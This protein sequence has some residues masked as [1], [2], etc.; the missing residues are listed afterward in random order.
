MMNGYILNLYHAIAL[1]R[2]S[3]PKLTNEN[4]KQECLLLIAKLREEILKLCINDAQKDN[5]RNYVSELMGETNPYSI[6]E[7]VGDKQ[8]MISLESYLNMPPDRYYSP[9]EDGDAIIYT[10]L[11]HDIETAPDV[12]IIINGKLP[13]ADVSRV[14]KK[15]VDCYNRDDAMQKLV[16]F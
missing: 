3:L 10:I 9:D 5:L 11:Q 1:N 4:D 15:M 16:E 2:I 14:L 8:K 6:E 12:Q 7:I 13:P